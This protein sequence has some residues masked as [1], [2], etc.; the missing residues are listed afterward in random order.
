M[1]VREATALGITRLMH[2][3]YAECLSDPVGHA[4]VVGGGI[5]KFRVAFVR[6]YGWLFANNRGP[7]D[8][9]ANIMFQRVTRAWRRQYPGIRPKTFLDAVEVPTPPT[10]AE[11]DAAWVHEIASSD[12]AMQRHYEGSA[13]TRTGPDVMSKRFD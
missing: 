2:E 10:Q 9:L 7:A 12:E 3:L 6:Q 5:Y 8:D 1:T 11:I 13:R 4:L